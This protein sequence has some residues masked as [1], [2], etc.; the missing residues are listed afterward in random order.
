[1]SVTQDGHFDDLSLQ[2]ANMILPALRDGQ[3]VHGVLCFHLIDRVTTTRSFA[4]SSSSPLRGLS[5]SKSRGSFS[6]PSKVARG[7][8]NM[9]CSVH[10]YPVF[11]SSDRPFAKFGEGSALSA[12]D[13]ENT[14]S[15]LSEPT[16][17]T[18]DSRRSVLN[19][20]RQFSQ[21][22]GSG[23][24]ESKSPHDPNR[25]LYHLIQFNELLELDWTATI[26]H[27]SRVQS[28]SDSWAWSSYRRG[29]E[30][31][32]EAEEEDGDSESSSQRG[33]SFLG[34]HIPRGRFWTNNERERS[35]DHGTGRYHSLK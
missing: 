20:S 14:L 12:E 2:C 17:T 11:P 31:E 18:T 4:S 10:A 16:S 22:T 7:G 9:M 27:Q 25:P 35:V 8:H 32:D 29:E 21:G 15:P 13:A 34:L 6:D 3:E 28:Q 19:S 30:E 26:D 5:L 23:T 33:F 24:E 1:M